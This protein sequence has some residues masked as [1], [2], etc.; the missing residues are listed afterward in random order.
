MPIISER[1]WKKGALGMVWHAAASGAAAPDAARA[2]MKR[3][4]ERSIMMGSNVHCYCGATLA[5]AR[6][7]GRKKTAITRIARKA[8][9]AGTMNRVRKSTVFVAESVH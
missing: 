7:A 2:C 4:R 1:L 5:G 3:R 9:P 8:M 6:S